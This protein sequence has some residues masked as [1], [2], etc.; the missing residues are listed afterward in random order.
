MENKLN[1]L[2]TKKP[3]SFLILPFIFKQP[4][5]EI[6]ATFQFTSVQSGATFLPL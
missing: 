6:R 3:M 4:T 5:F 2:G 1:G